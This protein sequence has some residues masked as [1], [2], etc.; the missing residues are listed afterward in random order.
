MTFGGNPV[1]Q[2]QEIHMSL[3]ADQILRQ[4]PRMQ[5]R[6]TDVWDQPWLM[7]FSVSL[8]LSCVCS[9]TVAKWK[10]V[11]AFKAVIKAVWLRVRRSRPFSGSFVLATVCLAYHFQ[12]WW[13]RELITFTSQD[14]SLLKHNSSFHL[15]FSAWIGAL[16]PATNQHYLANEP[17]WTQDEGRVERSHP[18]GY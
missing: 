14:D 11:V 7:N 5:R 12:G 2:Q 13:S 8:W 3:N 1:I 15:I 10:L 16:N 17:T 6:V 4:R 18:G 9:G